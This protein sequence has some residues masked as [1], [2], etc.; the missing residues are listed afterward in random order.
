MT[1]QSSMLALF[2][3]GGIVCS[4]VKPE[5]P[6]GICRRHICRQQ[7]VRATRAKEVRLEKPAE[8]HPSPG[9]NSCWFWWRQSA[10]A[11]MGW[12][13]GVYPKER[14]LSTGGVLVFI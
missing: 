9:H 1:I 11:N 4:G 8:K 14:F 10:K 2:L 7:T 6:W 5:K 12:I 13:W 3:G